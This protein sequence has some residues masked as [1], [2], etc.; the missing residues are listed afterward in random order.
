MEIIKTFLQFISGKGFFLSLKDI[1]FFVS[2]L[3]F[4]VLFCRYKLGLLFT[5]CFVFYL[6]YV[7]HGP[8]FVNILVNTTWGLF[9]YG[10][11]GF[12]MIVLFIISCFQ[13]S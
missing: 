11:A 10:I 12:V 5:Y 1:I 7:L 3:S 13:E 8:Y 4:C 6:G 9:L 2:F